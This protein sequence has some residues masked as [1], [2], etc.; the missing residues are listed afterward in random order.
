MILSTALLC[1]F[2]AASA[3]ILGSAGYFV[4]FV[5]AGIL[6]AALFYIP[7]YLFLVKWLLVFFNTLTMLQVLSIELPKAI[8]VARGLTP[9]GLTYEELAK[10]NALEEKARLE[11]QEQAMERCQVA[12]ANAEIGLRAFD[13]WAGD[14][15]LERAVGIPRSRLPKAPDVVSLLKEVN[16]Y[17]S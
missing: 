11:S 15:A 4:Y 10:R 12:R 5:L 9:Y 1:A 6:G 14:H 17:C 3:L 2:G 8:N 7:K 13:S 16:L